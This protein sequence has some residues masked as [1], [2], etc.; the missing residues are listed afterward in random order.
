[1]H[2]CKKS[3]TFAVGYLHN[4]TLKNH[5]MNTLLKNLGV[6][7]VLGGIACLAVYFFNTPKNALLVAGL[8][9]EIVGAV[10]Y[11]LMNRFIK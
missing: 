1:M 8:A 9:L 5:N 7:L 11:V 2:I 3:S 6:L 10:C 4:D